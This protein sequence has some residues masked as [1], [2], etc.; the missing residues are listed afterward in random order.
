MVPQKGSNGFFPAPY[1][2]DPM[3]HKMRMGLIAPGIAGLL[4]AGCTLTLISFITF[5]IF[6]WRRHYHTFIGYN[7]YVMLVLN[8]LVADLQQASAFLISWYWIHQN[9]I[10]APTA[11]CFAQGWLL[12]SGDVSSAFFV[13]AI[14]IHTIL[15]AV[16]SIEIKNKWFYGCIAG[17]WTLA[18]V[19]TFIGWG[20]H[21]HTYFVDA[22]AWCWVS[23]DYES[24]RLFLHYLWVFLVQFATICLYAGIFF[25]LRLRTKRTFSAYA[26]P[27][28]VNEQSVRQVNRVTKL[29]TLYPFVY[30]VLTLPLSAGRMWTMAHGGRATSIEFSCAAGALLASCGWVDAMLYTLT[31]RRLMEETMPGYK[32]DTSE[33]KMITATK[34]TTITTENVDANTAA[35][36]QRY[37]VARRQGLPL[38]SDDGSTFGTKTTITGGAQL[39]EP[40]VRSKNKVAS[41]LGIND[42]LELDHKDSVSTSAA[43]RTVGLMQMLAEGPQIRVGAGQQPK[44]RG[45]SLRKR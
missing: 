21:T 15:V 9:R 7:Q 23:P 19:L 13:L 14:A 40:E 39:E 31:R 45:W 28:L 41:K 18:Y 12:H 20:M 5:R 27:E 8:L 2:L 1:S 42:P 4:S 11:A 10:V 38:N 36:V 16:F 33:D 37:M 35:S 44:K 22:G 25:A 26:D 43:D 3:P 6:V 29:M 24:E 32:Q 17:I 30:V 34:T